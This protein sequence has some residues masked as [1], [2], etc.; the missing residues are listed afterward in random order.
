MC[1]VL[2]TK[3]YLSISRFQIPAQI[4][5]ES[6]RCFYTISFAS[7]GCTRLGESIRN[8]IQLQIY[9]IQKIDLMHM[10]LGDTRTISAM[11]NRQDL[12]N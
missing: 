5:Y 3:N 12:I 1:I 8:M 6:R 4:M 9:Y 10:A 2:R 7:I 11:P